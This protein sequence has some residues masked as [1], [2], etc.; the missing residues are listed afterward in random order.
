MALL[1]SQHNDLNMS[2]SR[3][4]PDDFSPTFSPD[5]PRSLNNEYPFP[6]LEGTRKVATSGRPFSARRGSTTSSIHSIGGTLDTSTSNWTHSVQEIGQNAIS[7]L[8]QSPIVRTG[9]Q[10]HVSVPNSSTFRAPTARDI[11]PVTLTN[12]PHVE[13]SEFKTYLS[14]VGGLYET[15]RRA[16][17]AEEELAPRLFRKSSRYDDFSDLLT[18]ENGTPTRRGLSRQAS[19]AS[20]ASLNT[21]VESPRAKRRVSGQGVRRAPQGPTPLSTIPTVYFD[22]AFHLENPRTFDIVSERSEVVK[23][24]SGSPDERRNGHNSTPRRA[25][26]TNAI[27]QEKLSWYMDT[28]EVHLISSISTASSS[29]FAALGSLRELHQE[30]ADSVARIKA[31]RDELNSLDREVATGGLEIVHQKRKRENLK[32]LSNAMQQL[33]C[34]TAGIALCE[35][36]VDSEDTDNALDAIDALERLIAGQLSEKDASI[37]EIQKTTPVRAMESVV[38]LQG[39]TS[40]MDTLRHK[41]G[42]TYENRFLDA[43]LTDLRTHVSTVQTRDILQRWSTASQRT[44]GGTASAPPAYLNLNDSFRRDLQR[45]LQGLH[46]SH[47]TNPAT[48]AY[49]EAVIREIKKII[50]QPLPSSND[51]DNE[52]V[53]SASTMGGRQ[54]SSQ[55]RSSILARNLRALDADS[56]EE[57]LVS[58]YKGVGESLRRL[59]TQ[60]KIL[61]DVTSTLG[62]PTGG[63]GP[64][65][66]PKSPN[67]AAIDA[68]MSLSSSETKSSARQIQE[69]MHQ[70]LD[71]S[72]LLGQAV[73]MAQNQIVKVLKVRAEQSI[74]QVPTRF[75]RYFT[76]NLLFANECEAV[77]GRSVTVLK[78]V[79]N[80]HIKDY[81]KSLSDSAQQDLAQGMDTDRWDAKDF[82]EADTAVLQRILQAS[83]RDPEIWSIGSKIWLPYTE[84][85]PII[86]ASLITGN[87][88]PT[89]EKTKP[90]TI[91]S[92][93]FILPNSAILCLH[94]LQPFLELITGLPSLSSDI[95]STILS[96]LQ[97]FN[98]RCTQ[99]ILGAGATRSVG[100]KNITTKHLALASQALSFISSL[101]P[102]IREFVRRHAGTSA[103][104]SGL[105]GE[106]DKVRRLYQE[107]IENISEKLVDI[108]GGRASMQVKAM[109]AI[110][111]DE[112]GAKGVSPYMDT[113]VKETST[114][115]KVLNRHLPEGRVSMIMLPVF[116][117]YRDVWGKAFQEIV[118][119]TEA[120]K[121]RY[122]SI[123]VFSRIILTCVCQIITRR[124]IFRHEI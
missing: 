114:L 119:E 83:D 68:R 112:K 23:P 41:I 31:L 73:D 24:A 35:S 89:K 6:R 106:F 120:G 71:M 78:T 98:S 101:I 80:A 2:T 121:E 21:P 8:L 97:L 86:E 66:P 48:A 52:S 96:Y 1:A 49:R 109:K 10:P 94:G 38:A 17:E 9:L 92:E 116:K 11:P 22:D 122:A 28:I 33:K 20:L 99:L 46:R 14:Q 39:V 93:T 108:M 75:L 111:W 45:N 30:A 5:S 82:L 91:E 36:L 72:N 40:D 60:V 84:P 87:S 85:E 107:H 64:M 53:M 100:L 56:A 29:F 90:A 37:L 4:T 104:V 50:K 102:H 61:L 88:V 95:S 51:D 18:S 26:A 67:M 44:R 7:T 117:I 25:L 12:I 59:G 105:M 54:L 16:K 77:S 27:L 58:I 103:S 62:D 70:A 123:L 74:Q 57:M 13:S 81:I 115:Y 47:H 15:L 42:K 55:D 113:L 69:E 43:L 118:L 34:I 110:R 3:T 79:V 19:L 124:A 63:A 32:Q 76:L 65:S